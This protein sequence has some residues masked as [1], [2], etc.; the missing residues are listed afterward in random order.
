MGRFRYWLSAPVRQL[1]QHLADNRYDFVVVNDHLPLPAVFNAVGPEIPIYLD[2]HEYFPGQSPRGSIPQLYHRPVNRWIAKNFLSVPKFVTV[3]SDQIAGLYFRMGYLETLPSV[4]RNLPIAAQLEPRRHEAPK[5]IRIVHH[6]CFSKSRN[7]GVFVDAVALLGEGY[8]LTFYFVGTVPEPFVESAKRK[9]GRRVHFQTLVSPEEIPFEMNKHDI[10]LHVLPMVS[11]NHALALPNKLFEFVQARLAVVV[12]P[13]PAM[14]DFVEN[15]GVGKVTSG[16]EA[17]DF[18]NTIKEIDG[19]A[20]ARFKEESHRLAG[21]LNW[22]VKQK[23]L[24]D[25]VSSILR[26]R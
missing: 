18:A 8:E 25:G 16:F 14:A 26:P 20:L 4:V 7:P 12:S 13:S 2:L 17:S 6:G 3:V 24:L 11:E 19:E 9:L 1:S 15:S 22:D 21:Q 10:G 5:P 23:V